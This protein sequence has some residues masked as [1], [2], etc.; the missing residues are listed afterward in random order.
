MPIYVNAN[1]LAVTVTIAE[2]GT[3]LVRDDWM[4]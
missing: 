2:K 4:K 1:T 3:S